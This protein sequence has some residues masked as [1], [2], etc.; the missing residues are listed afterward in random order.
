MFSNLV[1]LGLIGVRFMRDYEL[2]S[3][4]GATRPP[5]AA[6]ERVGPT[7]CAVLLLLGIVLEWLDSSRP[8]L[9]VNAGFFA[10]VGFAVLGKAALMVLTTPTA[11]YD[12]EAGLAI[13]IAIPFAVIAL[14]DFLLYRAT[15]PASS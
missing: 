5:S 15:R 3:F 9:V 7:V 10:V 8:A 12:P 6:F 13:A 11:Q 1:C 4:H 2:S 14:A